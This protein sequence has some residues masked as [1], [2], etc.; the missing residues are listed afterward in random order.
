MYAEDES[1]LE[2]LVLSRNLAERTERLYRDM[3]E[4]Y[5]RFY[6]TPLA[7]L[8]KE[9]EDEEDQKISWKKRKLRKRLLEFRQYL[10]SNY[11]LSTAKMNFSKI[12]T[13]YRH[14]EIELYKLPP[15][16]AK[17]AEESCIQ[18]KDLPDKE[19]IQKALGLANP[20]HR[21]IIL[22][23]SSSGCAAAETLSLRI[24]DLL[25]SVSEYHKTNDIYDMIQTLQGREDIVPT[26]QL[27]R[28]KTGKVYYTFCSPEA[29]N[30]ICMYLLKRKGLR[31]ND[32]LF[33]VTQLHLMQLFREVNNTLGLGTVGKNNYVRFRSHMLRKFHAST[34]YNDGM[35]LNDVNDLQGKTKNKTD[36]SYFMEDPDKLKQKYIK[37]MGSLTINLE[38][39]SLDIKSREYRLLEQELSEKSKEYDELKNR[40]SFI[41]QAIN[42]NISS[43]DLALINKY[44]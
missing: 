2:D 19:I 29:F 37:H 12:L 18:F 25:E 11:M 20:M 1:I 42:S 21:A 36:S 38:V 31:N 3:I 24:S 40:V 16:S 44:I 34:L 17:Q 6:K 39:T 5:T 32:R 23:M 10:Y 27:K 9:A 15:I 33:K 41:E 28:R 14:Y 4:K 13:I 7:V 8:L 26:F 35:S 30:E 22:F 43:D